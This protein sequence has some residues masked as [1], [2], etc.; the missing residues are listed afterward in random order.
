[1][2]IYKSK[3]ISDRLYTIAEMVDVDQKN[4][5]MAFALVIG[6]KWAAV[7]DTGYG[8][9]GNLKDYIRTITDKPLICLL[10]HGDPDHIGGSGEFD[11]VYMNPLDEALADESMDPDY[12][13]WSANM[14][15]QNNTALMAYAKEHIT[16]TRDNKIHY[17]PL[18]DG[19]V[20]D[21]GGITLSAIAVPGHSN[22]CT[23]FYSPE[24]N[25]LISGDAV[26]VRNFV[27]M[28][29]PRSPEIKVYVAALKRLQRLIEPDTQIFSGHQLEA[30]PADMLPAL[31][32]G[33]DDLLAGHYQDDAPYVMRFAALRFDRADPRIHKIAGTP[34]TIQ[35][36]SVT[37]GINQHE[38]KQQR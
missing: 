37:N 32:R 34:Y 7:I 23:A 33:C 19:Q 31:I 3:Q 29:E 36:S 21:L 24:E 1:M 10:T 27:Q 6:D 26:A 16:T 38:Y 9:C 30:F 28:A 14:F 13:I 5:P 17:T 4:A 2:N 8:L 20:F 25:F 11:T 35:Y 15:S 12:R 18:Y 22:G